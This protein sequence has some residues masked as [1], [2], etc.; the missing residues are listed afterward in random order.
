MFRWWLGEEFALWS[1][2]GAGTCRGS[3]CGEVSCDLP[4]V[5]CVRRTLDTLCLLCPQYVT[6]ITATLT[7][8]SPFTAVGGL[9][10]RRSAA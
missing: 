5:A 8:P 6:G 4:L 9:Q 2:R 7:G 3:Y 10:Q 1:K